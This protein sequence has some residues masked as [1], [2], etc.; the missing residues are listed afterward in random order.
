MKKVQW[1]EREKNLVAYE[2]KIE[3]CERKKDLVVR[4]K[5]F[6]VECCIKNYKNPLGKTD[7]QSYMLPKKQDQK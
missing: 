1:G 6:S 7:D 2:K 4:E 3:L 5:N